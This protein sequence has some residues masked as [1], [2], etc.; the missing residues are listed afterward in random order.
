VHQPTCRRTGERDASGVSCAP[1][2][3]QGSFDLVAD[4]STASV[5]RVGALLERLF[6]S[7]VT[8]TSSGFRIVARVDGDS[9][10]DLNRDLLTALRREERRTRLRA[11]WTS[12]G[13]T[14][15]FFDYVPKGTR[16]AS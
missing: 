8:A 15:R 4:V 12:A 3:Q 13:V 6:P 14:E 5:S 16:A 7:G 9:A 1:V 10:R 2:N 11:E